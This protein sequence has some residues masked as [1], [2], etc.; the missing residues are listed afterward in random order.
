MGSFVLPTPYFLFGSM[1]PSLR[2]PASLAV[3]AST[4]ASTTVSGP[5]FNQYSAQVPVS[6]RQA[7]ARR[8]HNLLLY[9]QNMVSLRPRILL[10]GE[11][12]GYRG[13]RLTGVPFTNQAILSQPHGDLPLFG[14]ENGF[15]IPGDSSSVGRE[16]SATIV[17]QVIHELERPPLLWNAFPF[18]PFRR[19]NPRSNR[20]PLMAE[21]SV[22]LP[23]LTQLV[24]LFEIQQ[25]VAVGNTAA[26]ALARAGLSAIRIRHPSHGG[27]Q[28]FTKGLLAIYQER[29]DGH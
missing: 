25:V 7:N 10:V 21:L 26:Q 5:V 15:V 19:G 6:L 2:S 3:L 11:A 14:E 23:I 13:C 28:A 24:Q 29:D 20:R 27:K 22:G 17:W 8:L 12:P 18:H 9:W 1:L 16:A 4:L